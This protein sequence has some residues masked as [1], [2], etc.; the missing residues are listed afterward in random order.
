MGILAKFLP[1][2]QNEWAMV[3]WLSVVPHAFFLGFGPFARA[4]AAAAGKRKSGS[5]LRRTAERAEKRRL[6][7]LAEQERRARRSAEKAA[8]LGVG[9]L[10]LEEDLAAQAVALRQD[11]EVAGTSRWDSEEEKYVDEEEAEEPGLDRP[12][13]AEEKKEESRVFDPGVV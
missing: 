2:N 7:D 1:E 11:E 12:E 5:Q 4:A 9:S 13:L 3:V 6:A 8:G 10:S